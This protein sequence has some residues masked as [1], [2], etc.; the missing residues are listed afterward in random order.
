MK[1]YNY[2]FNEDGKLKVKIDIVDKN[3][4]IVFLENLLIFLSVLSV[5]GGVLFFF[6]RGLI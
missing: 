2:K 6:I 3:R 5:F 4:G 1:D